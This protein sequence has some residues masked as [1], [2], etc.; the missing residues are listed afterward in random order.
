MNKKQVLRLLKRNFSISYLIHHFGY[1]EMVRIDSHLS[2]WLG[3]EEPMDGL[4]VE[5][6]RE[7]GCVG[8][9][10]N[11]VYFYPRNQLVRE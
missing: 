9:D 10:S 7:G 11:F 1:T 4:R 5:L 8:E 6:I 3:C 2:L